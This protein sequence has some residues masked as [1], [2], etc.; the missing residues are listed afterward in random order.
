MTDQI[1]ERT[2]L[3]VP[4]THWDREWYL[5]F[6]QFR[7]KLVATVDAV[8]DIMERDPGY[9][10]FL[11]DGQTI[12]LDDYLEVRPENGAR[13]QRLA[14]E[15]RIL[16]GPWYIQPDEFL[17]SGESLI[18][19]LLRGRRMARD[20][21]G[22]MNVGYVP[23]TFG[24]I[25]QLPQILGGFGM[26]EAVFWRGVGPEMTGDFRWRAPDGEAVRVVWLRDGYGNAANLPM[27]GEHLARRAREIAARWNA[28]NAYVLLMNG[29]DHL[30]PQAE[31]PETMRQANEW[32]RAD[33]MR[34]Q[35]GTLPEY[36]S[37]LP[38]DTSALPVYQGELRSS[39]RAPLLPA[40][41][42]ARVW[43]K[44][45]N[46]TCE[47]ALARWAEPVS[48]LA[49]TLGAD[50]PAGFLDLAWKLL[51]QN[52]PHDSICGCSIDQVHAEMLPRYDQS[53]QVAG[54]LTSA[55]LQFSAGK[56]E[57]RGPANAI[58]VIVFNLGPG[59]RTEVVEV[60]TL[61]P[62]QR[63]RVTDNTGATVPC[64][65]RLAEAE[66]IYRADLDREGMRDMMTQA[67]DGHIA[68]Y[69]I[70]ELAVAHDE[71]SA[72]AA[73]Q[74]TLL[75]TGEPDMEKLAADS[76]RLAELTQRDEITTYRVVAHMAPLAV[77]RL[78]ARDAPAYGWRVF[79]I[80]PADTEPSSVAFV[81]AVVASD[82]T[83]ENDLLCVTVDRA[84][85]SLTLLDKRTG[86]SYSG[87]NNI[88]DGG[89]I[90]DLYTYCPPA[91]D[92]LINR[93]AAPPVVELIDV[94]PLR[95]TLRVTRRYD[96]PVSA[97]TTRVK[98]A[99]E[100]V[101]C[102]IVSDVT[103]TARSPRVDIQTTIH[104]AAR[105]HRL[106]ALFSAP[107]P[108]TS[109]SAEGAFS[110]VKRPARFETASTKDWVEQPVN[111]HP[112][113]RFVDVSDGAYG[114]AIL[115]HGLAE[116]EVVSRDGGDAVAVTLLRSVG[117][118]SRGDL[119]TRDG[120]AGPMLATP[121]GQGLGEQ[122]ARYAILTHAGD[123][124]T[125]GAVLREAQSFEAPLRALP[126]E[127]HDGE[128]PGVWSFIH[129]TPDTSAISA[130]KRAESGEGLIVR[131]YNPGDQ[132]QEA[133]LI[134]GAPLAGVGEV[135]LDEEPLGDDGSGAVEFSRSEARLTLQGGQIRTVRCSFG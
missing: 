63:L 77:I 85:G 46:A 36:I 28:D 59:P 114:L 38:A 112:Q 66:E 64:E 70:S 87:L 99:D 109:A 52:Q 55:G 56:V 98:R 39:Y 61:A 13:L 73:V 121:G 50:Y 3:I 131:L 83:L 65:A 74:V 17:V 34:L 91:V 92:T 49:W 24:H 14:R 101:T 104:N 128:L 72:L 71:G 89:D 134:F 8:L 16:V 22:A 33:H 129:V 124:Q 95:A 37:H 106:R 107:F 86:Q 102:E 97:D 133:A 19:N 105:D 4:H 11:L 120:H 119:T 103:L 40:T 1:A 27:D 42:S 126:T 25:A 111:A 43:L 47:A 9:A 117:W 51:L 125:E 78:L 116:Y 75:E 69:T 135:R 29:S 10:R 81:G 68:G 110:V 30:P 118:L 84:D 57:T 96:L 76:A 53:E 130:I 127:Q 54:A 132:P 62:F 94:S 5:T 18:R 2:L 60:E 113:K 21:G 100:T 20:Y 7:M 32:L 12:I 58:P 67:G 26:E 90:G 115:N 6:Q 48:A 79:H 88:E 45:R 44:Q 82:D 80:G 23:D 41:L 93:P 108:I 123:W 35:I 31:L 15:G 122:T